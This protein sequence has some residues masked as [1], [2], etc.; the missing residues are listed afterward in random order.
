L[1][2][3]VAYGAAAW[4]LTEVCEVEDDVASH[5]ECVLTKGSA[6]DV[7]GPGVVDAVDLDHDAEVR[8]SRGPD[9]DVIRLAPPTVRA[10]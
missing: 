7:L 6:D 10:A 2:E 5:R 9:A 3:R 1:P 4:R 8:A